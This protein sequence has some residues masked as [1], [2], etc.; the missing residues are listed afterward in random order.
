[1]YDFKTQC[2]IRRG[3]DNIN[4]TAVSCTTDISFDGELSTTFEC[5][6]YGFFCLNCTSFVLCPDVELPPSSEAQNCVPGFFCNQNSDLICDTT[7]VALE[8]ECRVAGRFPDLRN[9]RRYYI[10][11]PNRATGGYFTNSYNCPGNS[12]FNPAIARCT[13]DP[14]PGCP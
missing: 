13:N 7:C 4:I 10:C 1:M 9:C 3:H 5:N 14:V 11:T 6:E 8:F 2:D 12:R